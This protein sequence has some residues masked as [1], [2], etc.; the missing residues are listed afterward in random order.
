MRRRLRE[1]T[2]LLFV[3]VLGEGAPYAVERR[4][5][6]EHGGEEDGEVADVDEVLVPEV[7]EELRE[8]G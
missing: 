6:R 8:T 4:N 3:Q 7:Y 2:G 5:L 1:A